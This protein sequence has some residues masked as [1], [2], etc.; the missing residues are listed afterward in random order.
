MYVM[1]TSTQSVW[2]A[3]AY[4][5]IWDMWKTWIPEGFSVL[6]LSSMENSEHRLWEAMVG[7][8]HGRDHYTCTEDGVEE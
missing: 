6:E 7:L 2:C 5:Y 8:E 1:H 4:G 3:Q